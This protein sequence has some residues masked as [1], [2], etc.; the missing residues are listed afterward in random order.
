M[1]NSAAVRMVEPPSPSEYLNTERQDTAADTSNNLLNPLIIFT[2]VLG[3]QLGSLMIGESL[4]RV[5][6]WLYKVNIFLPKRATTMENWKM[7]PSV[8]W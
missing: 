7:T 4:D 1:F 6:S 8:V 5:T 3:F 2:A